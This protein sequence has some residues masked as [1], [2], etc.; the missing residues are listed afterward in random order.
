MKVLALGIVSGVA[1]VLA[2]ETLYN[3]IELASDPRARTDMTAYE[4]FPL[5]VPY[6]ETPPAPIKVDTGRQLFVDDFLVADTTMVR[7][8]HKAFKDRR[9]PVLKPET[10]LEKG[11]DGRHSAMAAPFSGGVWYDARDKLFKC[12]YCAGW[13]EGTAYA[14]STDFFSWTRPNLKALPGTNRLINHKGSRDSTAVILDP[15]APQ[16]GD[17]FKMLIWSRPQGGELYLSQNGVKWSKPVLWSKSGDRSTVFYNPFRKVWCYSLRSGW[18][19]RSREYAESADFIGGASLENRVKWMR[20]D[21][22]D[23]PSPCH[24]YAFPE[25]KGPLF[26]PALYNLDAVAYESLMLSIFTIMQGP[27]NNYCKGNSPVPKM[28]ELHLGFS[29]DGFHFSRPNDRSPFIP[30]GRQAGTW[31]RGYLHSNAAICLVIGDELWFPYTGFAGGTNTNRNDD[32]N[33]M[34]ANASMGFARL[35]RDGFASMDAGQDEAT[36]TT[37]PLVFTR[38]DRLWVNANAAG[39]SL[40]VEVLDTNGIPIPGFGLA[41]C[42]AVAANSVKT[43]FTWKRGGDFATLHGCPI[44]L[45]FVARETQL[46]AFWFADSSGASCG[47][48]AGGGPEYA[49]LR[50]E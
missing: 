34:Y 13:H 28:T 38:G 8:W 12:W 19:G 22:R 2:A 36:L 17:R 43:A 31:D 32:V 26:K 49:S 39:G 27:E 20:A 21:N 18:H 29:R 40:C 23:L 11:I 44:R 10:L 15:D 35:R 1:L 25:R 48:L 9:S 16:G 41:D 24:I 7:T 30:A 14:Y 5:P 50:D 45:R 6:L 3:G 4:D 37:R 33:G 46:Y 42:E 47:Y